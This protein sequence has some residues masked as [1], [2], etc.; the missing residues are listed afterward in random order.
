MK[1]DLRLIVLSNADELGEKVNNHLVLKDGKLEDYRVGIDECRFSNGEGKVKILESIR[2]KDVFVLSDIGNYDM[3]YREHGR[4]HTVGPDEHFSD[5]KRV[6]LAA[7][8]HP[9]RISL[10]T[11]L[12]YES[13]QDKRKGRESLDCALGLQEI[14]KLGVKNLITFDAHNPTVSNA[15]P[16]MSFENFYPTS[17][18]LYE[19]FRNFDSMSE[20]LVL[21]PDFGAMERARY[22]AEMLGCDVGA[23]YKRRDYSKL[24]GGK[25]PIVE[26][27]YLGADIRG[28]N[29]IIVD[30][31]IASGGSILDV[32][33]EAKERGAKR[34][35]VAATF[36]LF[37]EGID[38]I[39]A[40]Y[41]K[42]TFD[43]IYST[44]LSYVPER[45]KDKEWYVDVD[46]S[47]MIARI[48]IALNSGKSLEPIHN[49][50][51][52]TYKRLR[53]RQG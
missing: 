24:I 11:P 2:N 3:T 53:R 16:T 50:K 28:K 39:E 1:K 12:L 52:E 38:R 23:F 42:G 29:V 31:M 51:V 20:L 30:D 37:T 32:A 5:I 25:N 49:E 17:T 46:C 40:E 27:A 21:A 19:M 18:I 35:F 4:V 14:E 22:Y 6:I 26:H 33:R 41:K 48:I 15:I 9:K 47:E 44:N 34:V 13:R 7:S 36:A 45:I 8:N 43:Y 10:I